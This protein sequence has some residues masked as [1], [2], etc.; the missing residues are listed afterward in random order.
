MEFYRGRQEDITIG[1]TSEEKQKWV[2][3]PP[4]NLAVSAFATARGRYNND[5]RN[6]TCI[7]QKKYYG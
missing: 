3:Y 5:F 2:A 7:E 4:F 6:N 1:L